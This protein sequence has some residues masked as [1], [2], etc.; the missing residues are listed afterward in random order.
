MPG[1]MTTVLDPILIP[2]YDCAQWRRPDVFL[3]RANGMSTI[4]R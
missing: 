2:I 1:N 4:L 3:G